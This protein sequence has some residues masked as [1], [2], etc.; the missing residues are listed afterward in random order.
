MGGIRC[1]IAPLV[2]Q[3]YPKATV[4]QSLGLFIWHAIHSSLSQH[5]PDQAFVAIQPMAKAKIR[6]GLKDLDHAQQWLLQAKFEL[7]VMGLN[8]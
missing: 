5:L 2:L 4:R 6:V 3:L 7:E 1:K 8:K